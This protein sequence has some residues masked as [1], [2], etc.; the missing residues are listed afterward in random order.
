MIGYIG[1]LAFGFV[2]L[3]GFNYLWNKIFKKR[4]EK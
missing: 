4:G 3:K 2:I 1:M